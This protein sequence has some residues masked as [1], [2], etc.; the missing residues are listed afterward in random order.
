MDKKIFTIVLV[1]VIGILLCVTFISSQSKAPL[2]KEFVKQQTEL[3]KK[4]NGLADQQKA[5][6]NRLDLFE[7]KW[8]GFQAAINQLGGAGDRAGTAPPPR[9]PA[10]D[11]NKVYDIDV[12]H[13][14]VAGNKNAPITL[15]E[16]VD[17]QCPFCAR[18]H[19]PM[20]EAANAFPKKVNYMI[21]NFPLSFHPQAKSAAK[22]A[23][24]AGEQGKYMEM[25]DALLTNGSNLTEE[26]YEQLAKD[27]GL[28]VKKFLKDYKE[29]DD[30]WEDYIQE[31]MAL[32]GRVDVRGT[33]TF[34]INGKKTR[35]R[36]AASFKREIEQI[37]NDLN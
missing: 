10:E 12:A 9:P 37:L 5:L 32:G 36:D 13:T 6:E 20:V 18:F 4:Q 7:A 28:N 19:P 31:D 16:F 30:Q 8:D 25:A 34:F 35:A 27:L 3:I 15:V 26:L 33:P 22:A 11:P 21:K 23:F 24:A 29:K 14:P 17:F 1:V 2:L